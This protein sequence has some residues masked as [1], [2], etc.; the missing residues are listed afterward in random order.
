MSNITQNIF[1]GHK[2]KPNRQFSRKNINRIYD[3]AQYAASNFKQPLACHFV[4][5]IDGDFNF[6]QTL[7]KAKHLFKLEYQSRNKVAP[8]FIYFYSIEYKALNR[9][10]IYVGLH[11]HLH[12]IFDAKNKKYNEDYIGVAFRNCLDSDIKGIKEV[13][14]CPRRYHTNNLHASYHNLK[15]ELDDYLQ[16]AFYLAKL[17]QKSSDIPF[18]RKFSSSHIAKRRPKKV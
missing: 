12:C 5:R 9:E 4:M 18:D 1:K 8:D 6:E 13:H 2:L 10:G 17:E 7:K 15:Y 11:V 14:Y 16:R 3:I